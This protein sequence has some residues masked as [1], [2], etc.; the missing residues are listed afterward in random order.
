[1]LSIISHPHT[2]LLR[3]LWT[4]ARIPRFAA[5]GLNLTSGTAYSAHSSCGL[6]AVRL[7]SLALHFPPH[8]RP[9]DICIESPD[10]LVNSY[11]YL[12]LRSSP[13]VCPWLDGPNI[14]CIHSKRFRSRLDTGDH[15]TFADCHNGCTCDLRDPPVL[16][17]RATRL[18]FG[19][20]LPHPPADFNLLWHL[21][22]FRGAYREFSFQFL[23]LSFS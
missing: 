8:T 23:S 15:N 18:K 5:H 22:F 12:E 14:V 9:P 10:K 7:S 17:W 13:S 16:V 21:C 6:R 2:T 11:C 20:L 4:S 1:M 19:G 3:T